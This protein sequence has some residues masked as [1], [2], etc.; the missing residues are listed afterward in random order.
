MVRDEAG[1]ARSVAGVDWRFNAW[2][3][4]EGGLYPDWS[5]D[6]Q[7]AGKILQVWRRARAGERRGVG[8]G[9]GGGRTTAAARHER[10]DCLRQ[11]RE[12]SVFMAGPAS[13]LQAVHL[14]GCADARG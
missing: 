5:L 8:W 12:N 4:H 13:A 11:G 14:A 3:G 6:D 9:E 2:G 7:V 10:K 1:G